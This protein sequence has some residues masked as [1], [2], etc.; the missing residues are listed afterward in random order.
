A[1]GFLLLLFFFNQETAYE[2]ETCLE[3]RRVLFR[4]QNYAQALYWVLYVGEVVF[5]LL[6]IFQ[7]DFMRVHPI[8]TLI[9]LV[10]IVGFS[11]AAHVATFINK[12]GMALACSGLTLIS[13]VALIFCGLF[14]R[15]D[16]KSTR[17]HS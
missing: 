11:V 10:L 6:L 9:C 12:Q 4:S 16:R 5:A 17:L 15:V 1:F 7:T 14:P 3:F 13:L 8:A 2:I